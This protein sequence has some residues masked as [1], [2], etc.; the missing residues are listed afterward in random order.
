[1]IALCGP[2]L[3]L[4]C[5][6][7]ARGRVSGPLGLVLASK[8]SARLS[9]PGTG[10]AE[11]GSAGLRGA[12]T[13]SSARGPVAGGPASESPVTQSPPLQ[14]HFLNQKGGR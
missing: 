7:P 10:Q 14:S 8:V 9:V 4:G 3:G 6:F 12:T 5:P 2:S 13:T 11:S 1:M